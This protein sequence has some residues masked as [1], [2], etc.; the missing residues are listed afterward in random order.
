MQPGFDIIINPTETHEDVFGGIDL[1]NANWTIVEE[2]SRFVITSKPGVVIAAGGYVDLGL[3]VK[4]I[5]I[6]TTTGNLAGRI[7]FGTGGG[8]TPYNNNADNN[9]YST[10]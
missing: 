8:E 9:T 7:V 2:A 5:K 1:N 3:K 4:A 6:P 10:N